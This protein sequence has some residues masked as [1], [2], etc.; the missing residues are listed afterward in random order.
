MCEGIETRLTLHGP[1]RR[2]K[3][4]RSAENK[5]FH[6]T[7]FRSMSRGPEYSSVEY[8]ERR[9]VTDSRETGETGFEWLNS[10]AC[11]PA[12]A[13]SSS[14]RRVLHIGVGTSRL[15]HELLSRL[16]GVAIVN[17]DFASSA[18]AAARLAEQAVFGRVRMEYHAL[19]L[20][21]HTDVARLAA[22]S[23]TFDTILDKST[24]DAIATG[25][26]VLHD[27]PQSPVLVLSRNLARIAAPHARWYCLSYSADRWRDVAHDPRWPW[28]LVDSFPVEITRSTPDQSS[29]STHAH[30]PKVYHYAYILERK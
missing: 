3:K 17:V 29:S 11:F 8:W 1:V 12:G 14:A 19:D 16:P 6:H 26:D 5:A 20:L 2:R 7:T 28:T 13:V 24:T 23:A 10:G 4:I 15:S 21:N 27:E 18:I 9:F 25:P 30:A 22:A